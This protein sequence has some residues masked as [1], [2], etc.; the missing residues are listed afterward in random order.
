[1]TKLERAWITERLEMNM[2]ISLVACGVRHDVAEAYTLDTVRQ[3]PD[4]SVLE[5]ASW[6]ET[7][8]LV[9]TRR[10]LEEQKK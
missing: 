3:L 1:M 10:Y 9:E 8:W 4:E 6:D 5:A 2:Y 7:R